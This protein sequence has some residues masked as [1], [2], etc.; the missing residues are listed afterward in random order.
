MVHSFYLM[1]QP[2]HWRPFQMLALTVHPGMW[3]KMDP[4]WASQVAQW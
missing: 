1:K 4:I 3:L 2:D